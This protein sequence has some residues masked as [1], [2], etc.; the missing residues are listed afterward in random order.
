ML[1]Q[2]LGENSDEES[3]RVAK[4]VVKKMKKVE[5]DYRSLLIRYKKAKCVRLRC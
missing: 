4:A 5:E 3:I 1:V 2:E